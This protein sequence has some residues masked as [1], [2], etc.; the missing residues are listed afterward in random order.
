[1]TNLVQTVND[2]LPAKFRD[3]FKPRDI[4]FH[5][6]KSLRR[7]SI[8]TQLQIAVVAFAFIL[9]AWSA[10]ATVRIA[11]AANAVEGDV[12][13]MERQV[14]EMQRSVAQIRA[15]AE[16]RAQV[17]ELRQQFLAALLQG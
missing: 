2:G 7:F 1:M 13:S 5:D 3:L 17:L 14:E 8:G 10:F 6:G 9:L 12:A 16:Q 15:A 11:T 4:F